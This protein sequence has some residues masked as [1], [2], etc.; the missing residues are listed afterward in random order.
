MVYKYFERDGFKDDEQHKRVVAVAAALEIIKASVSAGGGEAGL[1]KTD[2]DL[3][4][5]IKHLIPLA[6]AIQDALEPDSE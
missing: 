5:A 1:R 4:Y 2:C 6:D 3:E